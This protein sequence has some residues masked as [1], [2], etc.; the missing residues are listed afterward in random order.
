MA[1]R[2]PHTLQIAEPG[3]AA[4]GYAQPVVL[5]VSIS[6]AGTVATEYDI[7]P[8]LFFSNLANFVE[9]FWDKEANTFEYKVEDEILT[10]C[11]MAHEG[12]IRDERFR[13]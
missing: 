4:A 2:G 12:E 6:N 8:A 3:I 11:L 9:H 7:T 13:D 1:V 10:G 5:T